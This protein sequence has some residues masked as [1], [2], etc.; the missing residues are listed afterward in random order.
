MSDLDEAIRELR[1]LDEPV[2]HP[3][4][5]PTE[6]EVRDAERRC[7]ATFHRDLRQYLMEASDITYGALEPVTIDGGHTAI[8]SVVARA[9][10]LGV[11]DGLVPIC[12]DNGDFYCL[13]EDGKVAFWS[14]DGATDEQWPDLATWI[15]EVWIGGG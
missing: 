11:P 1:R 9:R 12:E 14:H 8:D 5:R 6:A 2:P 3:L 10:D 13:T 7:G 15:R 4:R